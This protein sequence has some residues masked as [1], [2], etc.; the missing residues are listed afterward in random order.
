MDSADLVEPSGEPFCVAGTH[1]QW[2]DMLLVPTCVLQIERQGVVWQL[3]TVYNCW[4]G[5][6][7]DLGIFYC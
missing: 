4:A 5:L 7:L 1:Q 3:V 6:G 2:I